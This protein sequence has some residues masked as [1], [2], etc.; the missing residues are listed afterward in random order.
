MGIHPCRSRGLFGAARSFPWAV[1]L[2]ATREEPFGT[3]WHR[4]CAPSWTARAARTPAVLLGYE[5]SGGMDPLRATVRALDSSPAG[6][7]TT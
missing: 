4:I 6:V 1:P 3:F 5:F 2:A 7:G